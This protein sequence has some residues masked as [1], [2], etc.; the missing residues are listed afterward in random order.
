MVAN[1]DIT[2][3][4]SSVRIGGQ[5]NRFVPH[6]DVSQGEMRTAALFISGPE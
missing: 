2:P 4:S 6:S 5:N 3:F 1:P